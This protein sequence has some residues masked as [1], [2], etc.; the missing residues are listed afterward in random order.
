MKAW[1][2]G[3]AVL[4]GCDYVGETLASF[5]GITSH[6]Y[7]YEIEQFQKEKE[8]EAELEREDKEVGSFIEKSNTD[9]E[10]T[11]CITEQSQIKKY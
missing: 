7:S 8:R 5:L 11:A 9:G 1:K 6:K 2:T 10:G 3:N 4:A